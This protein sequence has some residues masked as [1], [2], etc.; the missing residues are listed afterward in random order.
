M[1]DFK[2]YLNLLSPISNHSWEALKAFFKES[3]LKKGEYFIHEGEIEYEFG[4]LAEGIMRAFYTNNEGKEYNKKFFTFP[5]I[6]GSYSSLITNKPSLFSQQALTRCRLFTANYTSLVNLYDSYPDLERWARM[7]AERY[8]V[9][10][11]KKEVEIVLLEASE[12]YLNFRA[13]Y[14]GLENKI[15]QFHIASYLGISPT[16]L[17]RIRK[18]YYRRS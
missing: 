1:E 17:S 6:V 10:N 12:R 5:S 9:E 11:E 14:P 8:F 4:F 16:H 7:Y 13:N 3:E 18:E 2:N 15:S